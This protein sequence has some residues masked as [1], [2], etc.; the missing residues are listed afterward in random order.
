[1]VRKPAD[2]VFTESIIS[3][4]K[5]AA[6]E[7]AASLLKEAT[8]LCEHGHY[9]RA[10]FLSV[11]AIEETGKAAILFHALGRNLAAQDIQHRLNAEL[12]SHSTKIT[13]AFWSELK[14][15]GDEQLRSNFE[16]IAGYSSALKMGREPSMYSRILEDGSTTTPTASVQASVARDCVSLATS[17]FDKTKATLATMSPEKTTTVQDKYWSLG[18]K[19]QKVW[20]HDDFGE[21]LLDF[22]DKNGAHGDILSPA[23]TDYYENY[24]TKKRKFKTD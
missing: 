17:C 8:L 19:A 6:L 18:P 10:Y 21:Y 12:R 11:S 5:A 3:S 9:A 2:T 16:R 23:V 4:Y 15:M 22:I 24:L 13:A 1:M 14:G 7:N 20:E